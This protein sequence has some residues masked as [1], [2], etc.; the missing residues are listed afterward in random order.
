VISIADPAGGTAQ[1]QCSSTR[2][3]LPFPESGI[4]MTGSKRRLL[5]QI[6]D[7]FEIVNRGCI[8][9]ISDS[10]IGP[11]VTLH[12]GDEVAIVSDGRDVLKTSV[13]GIEL[14]S[15]LTTG[16]AAILLGPEASKSAIGLGSL[17]MKEGA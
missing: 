11:D 15:R 6:S 10:N 1:T 17:L 4:V 3:T 12:I 16:F 2:P 5:G 8:V 13:K 14:G 9:L 7:V